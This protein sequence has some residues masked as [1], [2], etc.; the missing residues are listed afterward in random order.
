MCTTPLLLQKALLLQ[1]LQEV[2]TPSISSQ[3]RTD[4]ASNSL[5]MPLQRLKKERKG[6]LVEKL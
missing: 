4:G 5:K 3:G 2:K 6:F 1:D